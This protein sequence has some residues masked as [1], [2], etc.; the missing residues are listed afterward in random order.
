L[1]RHFESVRRKFGSRNS[2]LA[3][4][5][6]HFVRHPELGGGLAILVTFPKRQV[7]TA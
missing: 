4:D 7:R 5:A 2:N 3:G 6:R 1:E